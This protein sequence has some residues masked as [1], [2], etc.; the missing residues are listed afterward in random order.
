MQHIKYQIFLHLITIIKKIHKPKNC[1]IQNKINEYNT[2]NNTQNINIEYKISQEKKDELF[3]IN[4]M[5]Q[6]E[7][8]D[9]QLS[10][11]HMHYLQQIQIDDEN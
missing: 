1:N 8:E 6:F 11:M 9:R 2:N 4:L 7:E 5:H 10:E 3:A